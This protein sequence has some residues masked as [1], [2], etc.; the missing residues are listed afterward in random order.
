MVHH[1]S[2][3]PVANTTEKIVKDKVNM[4]DRVR[5][6]PLRWP[7]IT[8]SSKRRREDQCPLRHFLLL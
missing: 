2:L 7:N 4:L 6:N 1:N 5:I 3:F 8:I